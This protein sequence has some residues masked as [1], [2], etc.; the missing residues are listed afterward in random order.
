MKTF[1]KVAINETRTGRKE[2]KIK[3]KLERKGEKR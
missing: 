3:G 1:T 2:G